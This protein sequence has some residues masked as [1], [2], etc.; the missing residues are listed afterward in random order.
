MKALNLNSVL[1]ADNNVPLNPPDWVNTAPSIN[2]DG[3]VGLFANVTS[4]LKFGTSKF[5][6]AR[7]WDNSVPSLK[8]LTE[9]T[10]NDSLFA[11]SSN[12]S[13]G[14]NSNLSVLEVKSVW[15]ALAVNDSVLS[16]ILESI[17]PLS[18]RCK[19]TSFVFWRNSS[20]VLVFKILD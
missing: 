16:K 11:V 5:A 12:A 18:P 8:T 1:L 10:L 6:A 14:F 15:P 2:S 3:I 4:N 20:I 9:P 13:P 19:I 7:P 17:R